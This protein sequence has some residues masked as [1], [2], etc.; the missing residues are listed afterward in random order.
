[1][2][3]KILFEDVHTD[4]SSR[5]WASIQA[6]MLL[7]AANITRG[8]GLT[9]AEIIHRLTQQQQIH[10]LFWGMRILWSPLR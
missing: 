2:R 6:F 3:M 10:C 7:Q 5:T 9:R 1:M 4:D 8:I